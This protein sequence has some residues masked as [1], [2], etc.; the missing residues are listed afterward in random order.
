MFLVCLAA[1]GLGASAAPAPQLREN[2]N[3]P[4]LRSWGE[5]QEEIASLL[6]EER[7]RP[8]RRQ[9]NS[10]LTDMKGRIRSGPGSAAT[11][12]RVV[13]L[14]ALAEA[15][16]GA[17]R[18]ALWD[19]GAAQAL[20]PELSGLDL[21]GFGEPG[22]RLAGWWQEQESTDVPAFDPESPDATVL[23]S[24]VVPP[25]RRRG[26]PMP[27]YPYGKLVTCLEAPV[28]VT[29]IVGSD[30][31]PRR[32]T[33]RGQLDPMLGLAA[34]DA[35]REWRFRPARLEGEPVAVYYNLT[36]NFDIPNCE[37]TP[38]ASGAR[39]ETGS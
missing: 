7:W 2:P 16:S 5:R 3:E 24:D 19:F 14:R 6:R 11:V 18:Q 4:I 13:L 33:L 27:R 31:I 34:L 35:T 22:E 17:Q 38:P 25:Q 39:G 23:E 20:L 32:P 37:R 36:V 28:I 8:A 10:L 1:I 26:V 15:G 29:M 21:A 9:A 12:A 30:G